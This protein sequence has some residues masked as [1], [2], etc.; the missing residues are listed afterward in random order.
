MDTC[1]L[2]QASPSVLLKQTFFQL[3]AND[4]YYTFPTLLFSALTPLEKYLSIQARGTLV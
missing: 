3:N 2:D 1:M 4:E